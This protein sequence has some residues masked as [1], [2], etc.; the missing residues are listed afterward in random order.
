[1]TRRYMDTQPAVSEDLNGLL[2]NF[3][4]NNTYFKVCVNRKEKVI[5]LQMTDN[6]INW[7]NIPDEWN[8]GFH[9]LKRVELD[10]SKL[11]TNYIS[12]V[13]IVSAYGPN[14]GIKIPP[15]QIRIFNGLQDMGNNYYL[16]SAP[17]RFLP[18][19][20]Q[21]VKKMVKLPP[22]VKLQHVEKYL[23]SNV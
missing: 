14:L 18:D 3:K 22:Q 11:F 10:V 17:I 12:P 7:S 15:K 8:R 9:E 16:I 4:D 5:R 2:H 19:M 21:F 20:I 6:P 1:M 23:V 13:H